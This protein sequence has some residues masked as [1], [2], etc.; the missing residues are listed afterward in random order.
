[1]T[2]AVRGAPTAN[3]QSCRFSERPSI[4]FVLEAFLPSFLRLGSL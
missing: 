2:A 4:A 3:P 1:L